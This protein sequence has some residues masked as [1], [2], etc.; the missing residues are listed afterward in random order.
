MNIIC[1]NIQGLM[2]NLSELRF[3]L[4]KLKSDICMCNETHLTGDIDDNE[5]RV[6]GYN[7]VR[8]N[9]GSNRTGGVAVYIKKGIKFNMVRTYST[10]FAWI[11]TFQINVGRG[12]MTIAAVYLSASES[13]AAI[14]NYMDL[15]CEEHCE[16]DSVLIA[17]DFNIDMG[18][19]STYAQRM[20]NLCCD[21]GLSQLVDRP[22]RV[23]GSSSTTIDLCLTNIYGTKCIV[24]DENQISD[25]K[26]LEIQIKGRADCQLPK[27]RYVKSWK[28]YSSERMWEE[29]DKWP[30]IDESLSVNERTKWL[31]HNIKQSAGSFIKSK[32]MKST[33]DFFDADLE[34]MRKEKNRLYKLAQFAINVSEEEK[35]QRWRSYKTYRNDYKSSIVEK[36]YAMNQVRLDKVKGDMKSTWR[37]LNSILHKQNDEI[38]YI[39]DN[40]CRYEIDAEIANHFNDFFVKSVVDLNSDIPCMQ[41]ECNIEHREDVKFVFGGVSIT[42]IKKHLSELKNGSDEFNVNKNVLSDVIDKVGIPVA[43]IINDSLSS[44]VFPSILKQSTVIPIRKIPGTVRLNEYRPINMLPCFEK[45]IEKVVFEQL[46]DYVERNDIIGNVQSGFRKHHSCE[47]AINKVLYDWNEAIENSETVIAVFLDFQRA[48][49]TIEPT[50]LIKKL[51]KYGVYGGALEW[52]K[53]YLTDRTQVVRIGD[54]ISDALNVKFGVPQGSIL[55]PLLFN[56]YINDLSDCLISS[57]MKLFADDTLNYLVTKNITEAQ[58]L[59]NNDLARLY[60]RIC[61]N[62]LKLNVNKTKAMVITRR[63]DVNMDDVNIQ[64]AGSRIEIVKCIKYLGIYIDN[65]LSFKENIDSVCLKMGRKVGV[66]SRLRNELNMQQKITIY[67]TTIEPHLTYCSTV[68]FMANSGEMDRMQKVQNRCMRNILK[69]DRRS[70]VKEMLS[71]LEILS[72]RQLI[73]FNTLILIYKML[74]GKCPR[75]LC[76]KIRL[77]CDN[78]RGSR[79]RNANDIRTIRATK[80]CTQNTIF[81]KGVNLFNELPDEMKGELNVENFKSKLRA[82]VL[83]KY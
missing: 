54:E 79:L 1:L 38:E 51:A 83:S 30:P 25:H 63:M 73:V 43:N 58:E 31:L 56:L 71:T 27:T 24:S 41:F 74:N 47:T 81:Y 53:G 26:I 75:Y 76:D 28:D 59:M 70:N 10:N 12:N 68:L 42:E 4:R 65:R 9:S 60:T 16:N 3:V 46:S 50:L 23:T 2:N 36:K 61:Q 66:L 55:G 11:V 5:M 33:V 34:K 21:N 57:I 14:M 8:C 7:V 39:E 35:E 13:K 82:Y 22:S 67:R 72:C 32:R 18:V 20:R 62:K 52:F 48:F 37:V 17:G 29:V 45:L 77:K 69:L 6:V 15:W 49:E 44:G 19:D 64:M 78:E 80:T 40:E